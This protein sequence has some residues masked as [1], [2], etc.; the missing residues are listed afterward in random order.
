MVIIYDSQ[1]INKY[2]I[3][4]YRVDRNSNYN[5]EILIDEFC[6][7]EGKKKL[8]SIL[9]NNFRDLLSSS[10]FFFLVF[11]VWFLDGILVF[12]CL[13]LFYMIF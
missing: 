2:G 6:K 13:Y 7:F 4:L 11:G 8:L 1:I 3:H 12:F 10:S 5:Y 9:E